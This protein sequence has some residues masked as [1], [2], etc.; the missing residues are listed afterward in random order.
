M[1]MKKWGKVFAAMCMALAVSSTVFAQPQ[2][3]SAALCREQKTS[4]KINVEA[5]G[6]A[7]NWDGVTNVSQF[8]D[9]NGEYCFAYD[10]GSYVCVV[11]TKKGVPQ[12]KQI[13]LK[14]K[15]KL[16]GAV[17]CDADGYY[18]VVTGE[19]NT[20]NDTGKETVFITKYD[21]AGRRVATVGDNG[22]SS[23]AYY[24]DSGY[25]TK[26]PF[27]AGNC[28]I[29]VNG[30]YVAVNYA[31][32]MYSGHQSNSLFVVDKNTMTLTKIDNYYNSHSFAQRVI[33]CGDRFLL[34]SEGD[35]YDRAFTVSLADAQGGSCSS[36]NTFDFWV[37]EGAL[38]RYD[39]FAI[40]NNYAHL[41]G[42]AAC[43][44]Q[45]AALVATSVKSLSSRAK[46]EEEQL[47]I[48]IFDPNKQLDSA[49]AYVT[50]G[51]RS[52]LAGP[53]GDEQVT[54]YGVKW[55]TNY[56][57]SYRLKNPQVVATAKGNYVIL[58]ERYKDGSYQGV[59]TM[60]V[61]S[62]GNKLQKPQLLS[63]NA[64]LNPG[65]MPVYANGRVYWAGN[66]RKS[67]YL[68]IYSFAVTV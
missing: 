25:Y 39:M 17:T 43:T 6:G 14:K 23:L 33:P 58:F 59:Y 32:E 48:Q 26:E 34:A 21:G 11:K 35:C 51:R 62:G 65:E 20:G 52:G 31:R 61:D 24:F 40:N 19:T 66:H 45:N 41:G 2:H 36:S 54:N 29:A 9:E 57:H 18:Y 68:Y 50:A 27:S 46:K 44:D 37:E 42:I 12:K 8:L 64:Y 28:D 10:K 30:N 3:V 60:T 16:F 22:S 67:A 55:L 1:N 47:F 15:T 56:N 63:K 13:K 4:I 7:E 53:N 38:D 49:D 5:V